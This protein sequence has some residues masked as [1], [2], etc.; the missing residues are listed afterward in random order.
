MPKAAFLCLHDMR[1]K[2]CLLTETQTVFVGCCFFLTE[3]ALFQCH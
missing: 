1:E 2:N 3:A